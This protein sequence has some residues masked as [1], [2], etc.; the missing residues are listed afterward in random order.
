LSQAPLSEGAQAVLL[1]SRDG[2]ETWER[3]PIAGTSLNQRAFIAAV[4]PTDPD[5][6]YVRVRGESM[7]TIESFLLYSEDAG[8]SWTEIF[9]GA[10]DLL[11]FS[12]SAD[13]GELLLGVG[14]SYDRTGTRT[15]DPDALGIY[16]A[17]APEFQFTHWVTQQVSC[18][19]RADAGLFVCGSHRSEGFEVGLLQ[20]TEASATSVLD[21]GGVRGPLDCGPTARICKAEWASNCALLGSCTAPIEPKDESTAGDVSPASESEG[22][23][24]GPQTSGA[25]HP[26]APALAAGLG[27]AFY[28]V[29]RSLRRARPFGWS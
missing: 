16:R 13:G 15:I 9:R 2:G 29:R 5:V 12:L 8:D 21:F 1:R 7:G 26:L 11:G 20:G 25:Q 27:L 10:A 23:S 28:A 22:C 3:R 19:T 14:D 18:L 6:L 4:H 24:V 17:A